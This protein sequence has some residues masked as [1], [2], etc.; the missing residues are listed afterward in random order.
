MAA[1]ENL[2]IEAGPDNVVR[3]ITLNGDW[4]LVGTGG[5]LCVR[6]ASNGRENAQEII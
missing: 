5:N 2:F 1:G 6:D 3:T 4:F